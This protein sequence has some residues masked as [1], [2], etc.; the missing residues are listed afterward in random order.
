M[1]ILRLFRYRNDIFQSDIVFSEIG[2]KNNRCPCRMSDIADIKIN[3]DAYLWPYAISNC[4]VCH[5]VQY[6]IAQCAT[7]CN[8][9]LHSVPPCAISN[10]TVCH[11]VQYQIAQCATLCNIRLHSVAFHAV[12]DPIM[13]YRFF[14]NAH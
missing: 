9:K 6:Q 1:S 2:K 14:L 8:I 13:H 5:P 10:C 4:A 3:V 7:L 12:S 11:P